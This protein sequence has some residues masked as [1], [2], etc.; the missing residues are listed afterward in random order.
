[1]QAK[2]GLRGRKV[3]R[4]CLVRME[5]NNIKIMKWSYKQRKKTTLSS[6]SVSQLPAW[7]ASRRRWSPWCSCWAERTLLTTSCCPTAAC[8]R[9]WAAS[10]S[11]NTSVSS[12]CLSHCHSGK[13]GLWILPVIHWHPF[14]STM[15]SG[16][17]EET[18]WRC[19]QVQQPRPP[20][21]PDTRG[22]GGRHCEAVL[23]PLR[24]G[25]VR[26]SRDHSLHGTRRTQSVHQAQTGKCR[27]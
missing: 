17:V 7:W 14:F 10:L 2:A 25:C 6:Q 5:M 22:D 24:A 21:L 15:H 26:Q 9:A 4:N 13:Q 11:G 8:T 3:W 16:L 12:H 1:M 20:C 18:D 19:P 27:V 23:P